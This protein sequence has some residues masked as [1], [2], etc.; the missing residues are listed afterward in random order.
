[1][2][3]GR[4]QGFFRKT[5]AASL[6]GYALLV[7]LIAIAA[8]GAIGRIGEELDALFGGV[9]SSLEVALAEP[10]APGDPCANPDNLVP[11]NYGLECEDGAFFAGFSDFGT[12]PPLF[13]APT[14]ESGLLTWE[15]PD[16]EDGFSPLFTPD[17]G[18]GEE[19][20]DIILSQIDD[21]W[22]PFPA[23]EAC[24]TRGS[25]WFLPSLTEL[26]I[27]W[28]NLVDTNNNETLDGS[29]QA[30]AEAAYGLDFTSGG[31]R[32]WS[33]VNTTQTNTAWCRRFLTN[34]TCGPQ[35]TSTE[36]VRCARR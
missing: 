21:D 27:I 6:I 36:N 1:M 35:K 22:G 3:Q 15:V 9:A 18:D 5:R 29:E 4:K 8:I 12:N 32:Y 24:R 7:G 31:G 11:E 10:E 30:D 23:A 16:P 33:S 28:T 25:Q 19:L 20:T 14:N 34:G 26:G 13:I 17:N 2:R